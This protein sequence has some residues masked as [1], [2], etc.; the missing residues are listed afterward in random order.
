MLFKLYFRQNGYKRLD[1]G[2]EIEGTLP[3]F[4]EFRHWGSYRSASSLTR[5]EGLG[6]CG[7]RAVDGTMDAGF[8]GG[9]VHGKGQ[10][11]GASFPKKNL[12]ELRAAGPKGFEVAEIGA[13]QGIKL[14]LALSTLSGELAHQLADLIPRYRRRHPKCCGAG[15]PAKA[16]PTPRNF[17]K[18]KNLVSFHG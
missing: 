16:R 17:L 5:Y 9:L 3:A 12:P 18:C 8:D 11:A 4:C 10:V 13:S 14:A 1:S 2:G 15:K 7:H 6:R